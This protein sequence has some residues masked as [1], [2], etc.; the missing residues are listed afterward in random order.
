MLEWTKKNGK[1]VSTNEEPATVKAAKALGWKLEGEELT[2]GQKAAATRASN[3]LE[4]LR[5]EAKTRGI[6]TNDDDTAETIQALIDADT[7]V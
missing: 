4:S 6:A 7:N 1:Q 3:K 2:Q 5:E